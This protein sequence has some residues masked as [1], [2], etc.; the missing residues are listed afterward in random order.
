MNL[1]DCNRVYYYAEHPQL[2]PTYVNMSELATMAAMKMQLPGVSSSQQPPPPPPQLNSPVLST[3]SSSI[4]NDSSAATH[5]PSSP[6]NVSSS[7]SQAATPMNS[8]PET[9]HNSPTTP[10]VSHDYD[11]GF[12]MD[13]KTMSPENDTKCTGSV[14]EK[15]SLF[16]R[17]EGKKTASPPVGSGGATT[18]TPSMMSPLNRSES[19][20][21]RRNEEIYRACG[22]LDSGM[23]CRWWLIN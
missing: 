15:A 4:T 5:H 2:Q 9:N 6:D 21:G 20:Y 13:S 14:I 19:L 1:M 16:E 12:S 10:V 8:A 23:S 17:L 18:P 22:T 3:A 7:T 11:S